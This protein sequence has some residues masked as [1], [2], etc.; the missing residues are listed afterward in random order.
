M[1]KMKL[2]SS[3]HLATLFAKQQR[4]TLGFASIAR[5]HELGL[6]LKSRFNRKK[7]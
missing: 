4:C 1:L 7:R 3:F 2:L 5:W 6:W